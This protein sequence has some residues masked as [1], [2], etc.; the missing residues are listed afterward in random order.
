[1]N[2]KDVEFVLGR[3]AA[4]IDELQ[5][6]VAALGTAVRALMD[7][8]PDK[9][10]FATRFRQVMSASMAAA[11]SPESIDA[12]D[13]R[14]EALLKRISLGSGEPRAPDFPPKG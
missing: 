11:M 14:H 6:E 2:D 8:E 9:A 4:Q 3:F 1:M 13:A 12:H 7:M 5:I 10:A